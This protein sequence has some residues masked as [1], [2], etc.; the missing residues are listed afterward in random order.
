[1]K[2]R[3]SKKDQNGKKE[4]V[5]KFGNSE[6]IERKASKFG[7]GAHIIVPKEFKGKKVKIIFERGGNE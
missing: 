1:M 2:K 3:G 4:I 6:I 7:T 5:I